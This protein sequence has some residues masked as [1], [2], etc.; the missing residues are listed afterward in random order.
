META[1]VKLREPVLFF[2]VGV[3]MLVF[4]LILVIVFFFVRVFIVVS[5][6]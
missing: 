1:A 5:R 6:S 2:V 4:V 3:I